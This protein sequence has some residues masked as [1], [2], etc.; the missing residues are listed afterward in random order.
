MLLK[1]ILA[2][3]VQNLGTSSESVLCSRM[4]TRNI[5]NTGVTKKIEGT[6][7]LVTEIVKLLLIWLLKGLLLLRGRGFFK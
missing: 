7:Y 6:W 4:K 2:T 5:K 3:S 1:V